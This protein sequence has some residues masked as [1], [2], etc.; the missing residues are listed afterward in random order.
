MSGGGR[1]MLAMSAEMCVDRGRVVVIGVMAVEVG[2]HE[3]CTPRAH[4]QG[5]TE[6]YGDQPTRHRV[7]CSGSPQESQDA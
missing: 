7:H 1:V 6:S 5:G 2:V 4:L 3:R